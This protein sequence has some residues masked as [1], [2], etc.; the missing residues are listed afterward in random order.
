M[1]KKIQAIRG[2]SDLLPKDS[3]F[4][5]SLERTIFDLFISYGYQNIR[6]PI[7]EKTDTF[8]RAIGGATD[9]VEKEMYSWIESGGESLSLNPEGTAGCVRMMI[10]HNLPREGIQKV[11]Y[12]GAMFRRERPQKGRY[13]QFHQVGLEVFGAT[14]AKVDAE[15]MMITHTLWQVL[16]L[17]N[18]VLE[19]NTLG[20][21]E[22]RV[23]Y[24][25]ILIAY[26]N[27]YKDQLDENSLKR[28]KTNPLRILDSK[29]KAMRS[30]INNAPKLMDYLDKESA[31]H[32][33]QFK[34]YLDAL[35]VTYI[36][37]T[38]LVRGL[39]YYNRTVFEWTT[40]NLGAQGTI[41][42][43]GRYDGL[44]EKMG[45]IPTPAV[46]LAI[47]L[48]RLILLLEVQNLMA[49]E[50]TLSIYLVALGEKAQIKSMQIASTLHDALPNVILYNDLTLGSFKSQLKKANKI[51]AYFALILGEQE[52]NNNQV[53]IKPLKG[54][55]TQQT[56]DLE[57][58][59]KYLK[60]NK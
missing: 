2:M 58:A 59:I 32:F 10:E 3:A 44:V 42:A 45:G 12:Q 55:G 35:N 40:T 17:K 14:N 52:L 19:I 20:S 7:V 31:Q 53:S 36:I 8:C 11:F 1:S 5:L 51:K 30:L 39:D 57:E 25:K 38:C 48:E 27:Q 9:I 4:W 18:I 56:M 6:T 37:N 13:R 23:A 41:C 49:I 24:R 29:N 33:E 47:G 15:L 50:P 22:T 28:L 26:F 21:S 34:T 54:Q 46:G 16:G 43:G 60:E